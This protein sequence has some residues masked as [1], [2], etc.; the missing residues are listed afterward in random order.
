[1]DRNHQAKNEFAQQQHLAKLR[2]D[3]A[4]AIATGQAK[5]LDRFSQPL[6]T[7]CLVVWKTPED[8]VW[9]VKDVKPLLDPKQPPGLVEMTLTLTVPVLFRVNEPIT[10]M[11]RVGQQTPVVE[12]QP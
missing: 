3:F 9:L 7:G 5:C 2:R 12:P 4:A 6:E 11:I 10:P 1:M 8:L